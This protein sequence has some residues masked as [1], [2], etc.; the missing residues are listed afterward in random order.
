MTDTPTEAEIDR[1]AKELYDQWR[2]V[3]L[4]F[5]TPGHGIARA[6]WEQAEVQ[7]RDLFLGI[8]EDAITAVDALR[9]GEP[10]RD[11]RVGALKEVDERGWHDPTNQRRQR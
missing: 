2:N 10:E 1:I 5:A 3:Q 11:V 8:G 7:H 4:L 9:A 6:P